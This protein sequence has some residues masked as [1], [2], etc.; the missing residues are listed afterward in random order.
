M[1]E[2]NFMLKM[3]EILTN[4]DTRTSRNDERELKTLRSM[5]R[6]KHSDNIMENVKLA[7]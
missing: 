5:G 6:G 1:N 4:R 7:K 2:I 3:N